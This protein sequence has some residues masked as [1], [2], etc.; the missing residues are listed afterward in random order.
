MLISKA[1]V[2]TTR[3]LMLSC[4]EHFNVILLVKVYFTEYLLLVKKC[5]KTD[6]SMVSF[7]ILLW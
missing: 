4:L 5:Q 2:I 6:D 7:K 1:P 3:R